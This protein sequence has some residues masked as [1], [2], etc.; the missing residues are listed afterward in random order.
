MTPNLLV[1]TDSYKISH[2]KMLPPGITTLYSYFESRGGPWPATFFGLQYILDT[3]LEGPVVTAERINEAEI[4][5]Q[6][7]FGKNIF[8]R[9]GWEYILRVHGGRLPVRIKAVPEGLTVPN[10]HVLL[11]IENTDP[12]CAWLTNYLETLLVQVWYPTTV[13]SLSREMRSMIAGYLALNGDPSL[14]DFKLHDFGF[15]GVSSVESAA[16]GGAAHLV[17]FRGTDTLP[18]LR[19]LRDHYHDRC[20]GHSIPATEHSTIMAWGETQEAGAYR[21]L[22][23]EFPEGLVACVSDTYDLGRAVT[24]LWGRDLRPLVFARNGTLVIR[25]DS[26]NPPT[27]V[28][29]VVSDLYRQFGG[30]T[31]AKGYLVLDPHVRVIQGDGVDLLVADACLSELHRAG[32]SADNLAFGMG[33]ALLQKLHR[34]TLQCAFKCSYVAGSWGERE[35]RKHPTG[36]TSKWSKAGRLR[37]SRDSAGV[38]ATLKDDGSSDNVLETVFENGVVVKRHTLDEI[39]RRAWG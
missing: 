19:L 4:L 13:C 34:D 6:Q 28:R 18:A 22:L 11:T 9:D 33:G 1:L 30:T 27:T 20:A 32:F 24:D 5:L 15:R 12:Q 3:Y 26:G 39:R 36:D 29:N 2:W 21:H 38:Y 37:L 16:I 31:N 35:V 8:N 25:P 17:N 14:V 7:H 10:H 23:K